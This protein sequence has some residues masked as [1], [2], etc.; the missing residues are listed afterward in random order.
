[1]MNTRKCRLDVAKKETFSLNAE[2]GFAK[3]T[4]VS[5]NL[6]CK[7]LKAVLHVEARDR[8]NFRGG[9]YFCKS[10]Q[11]RKHFYPKLGKISPYTEAGPNDPCWERGTK[12]RRPR[13][14]TLFA[15]DVVNIL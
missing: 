8:R 11:F 13:F 5:L 6:I 7:S 2:F 9:I 1:M 14:Y 4:C 15:I 12:N 3:R 10:Y